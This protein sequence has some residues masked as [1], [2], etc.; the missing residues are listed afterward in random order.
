MLSVK[1]NVRLLTL[2]EQRAILWEARSPPIF[3]WWVVHNVYSGV[4]DCGL[5]VVGN[6]LIYSALLSKV[7]KVLLS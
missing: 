6:V 3:S 4:H 5:S 7:R 1:D 2:F